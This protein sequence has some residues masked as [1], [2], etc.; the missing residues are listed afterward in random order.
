MKPD[1]VGR[2]GLGGKKGGQPLLERTRSALAMAGALSASNQYHCACADDKIG[3]CVEVGSL[4]IHAAQRGKG[5]ELGAGLFDRLG[6]VAKLGLDIVRHGGRGKSRQLGLDGQND[7][8]AQ[9]LD[10]KTQIRASAA[11]RR[12]RRDPVLQGIDTRQNFNGI[13]ARSS[14]RRGDRANLAADPLD[15]GDPPR[16]ISSA[17]MRS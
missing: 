13:A 3:E 9:L 7:R 8:V 15:L 14:D 10:G 11:A 17:S 5:F 6:D 16:A 1:R 4:R 2:L 12:H